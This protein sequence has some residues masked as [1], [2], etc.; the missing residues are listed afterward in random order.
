MK[1]FAV[2]IFCCMVFCVCVSAQE[3]G[4]E[5]LEGLSGAMDIASESCGEDLSAELDFV[6]IMPAGLP[7]HKKT[8]G[9]TPSQRLEMARIAF[10]DLSFPA[11]VSDFEISRAGKSYTVTTLAEIKARH[12]ESALYLYVGTDM[13]RSLESW[14]MPQTLFSLAT[15]C[16]MAREAGERKENEKV[17][18]VYEEKYGARIMMIPTLPLTVSS[19]QIRA[20]DRPDMIP[21]GVREFAQRE[22]LYQQAIP[23]KL[24]AALSALSEH[25]R[26]H[27]VSVAR[28]AR[29]LCFLLGEQ[30]MAEEMYHAALLHDIT[31]EKGEDEQRA[32]CAKYGG[33]TAEDFDFPAVVHAK[34]GA[35]AA[36]YEF[37]FSDRAVLAIAYHTTGRAD[38]NLFEKILFFADYIEPRRTHA[39]CREAR[40]RF[41]EGLPQEP[42]ARRK[43]LDKC[44]L[45]CLMKTV[46]HLEEKGQA[47]HPDTKYAKIA[48]ENALK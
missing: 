15:V 2:M 5:V 3:S 7:P 10:S 32:L 35:M 1:I 34:T 33:V 41:Y 31:R 13:F 17:A 36:K 24:R 4:D 9:A 20:G 23:D 11:E 48:L 45:D 42:E 40:K 16:C 39:V 30:G 21:Q 47:V 28:E 26:V 22:N 46:S 14:Y 29:Y 25:R 18:R 19:T 27:S 12:P 44:I 6:Y 38:M 8:E 37:S 43:W